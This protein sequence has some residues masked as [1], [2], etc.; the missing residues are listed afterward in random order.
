MF[1]VRP[2]RLFGPAAQIQITSVGSHVRFGLMFGLVMFGVMFGCRLGASVMFS[3]VFGS[4]VMI[5][6]VFGFPN[7]VRTLLFKSWFSVHMCL[8]PFTRRCKFWVGDH[9][10]SFDVRRWVLGVG[11]TLNSVSVRFSVYNV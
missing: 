8:L 4:C 9:C 11:W 1:G 5:V 2:E 6:F 7:A 10:L 3:V